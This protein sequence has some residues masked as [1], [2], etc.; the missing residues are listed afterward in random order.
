MDTTKA[1]KD[2]KIN[3]YVKLLNNF[4]DNHMN[5]VELSDKE[6]LTFIKIISPI[7]PFVAEEIY[8]ERFNGKY[9]ILNEAWPE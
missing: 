9:S 5:D 6:C 2:K 3:K 4:I 7:L 1:L 8:K